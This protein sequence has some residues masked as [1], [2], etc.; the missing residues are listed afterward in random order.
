MSEVMEEK[1]IILR[2]PFTPSLEQYKRSIRFE[3]LDDAQDEALQLYLEAKETLQPKVVLIEKFIDHHTTVN[4]LPSITIENIMFTGKALRVLTDVTRVFAYVATCGTELEEMDYSTLDM[5]A[6]YW[7]DSI[8]KQALRDARIALISF[9]KETYG[10]TTPKSLNPGSGNVDIWPIE[11]Q[12]GL[13][14]ILG[15]TKDIG[16]SLNES[17]LMNPN[18]SISG[19]MFANLSIDYE[20]CAYCERERCPNRRVP[21]TEIM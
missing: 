1:R 16:V 15:G 12:R 14:K 11:E 17:C 8:K 9:V 18:K 4:N 3:D 2:P 6:P 20:S 21:F 13:F 5:L 10:I 7:V 19:F